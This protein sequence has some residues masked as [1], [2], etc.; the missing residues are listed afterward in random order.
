MRVLSSVSAVSDDALKVMLDILD[1]EDATIDAIYADIQRCTNPKNAQPKTSNF[2]EIAKQLDKAYEN[3]RNS[4]TNFNKI[5]NADCN[6]VKYRIFHDK[7]TKKHYVG[8][9]IIP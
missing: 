9:W 5:I 4:Y 7:E 6:P 2:V 8:E 3:Y 1:F